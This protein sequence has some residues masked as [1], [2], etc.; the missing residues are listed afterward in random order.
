MK[1][2]SQLYKKYEDEIE[3][4]HN[5]V[6]EEAESRKIAEECLQILCQA[7]IALSMNNQVE[8]E[9]CITLA[10]SILAGAKKSKEYQK[11]YG[12]RIVL[13][14][15]LWLS[16]LL[17]LIPII[18]LRFKGEDVFVLAGVPI[19][20]YIWGGVG[21]ITS[22]LYSFITHSTQ[23]N[24]DT[25]LIHSYYLKPILGII[26]GPIVYFLFVCIVFAMGL[27]IDSKIPNFL[28]LLA[29]WIAGFSERFSLGMLDTVMD[30]L[31]NIHPRRRS[32][33]QKIEYIGIDREK[34]RKE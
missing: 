15:L 32:Q 5:L 21:G 1:G 27:D 33:I 6:I 9:Y 12:R 11:S 34:I 25:Q 29:C 10:K 2:N 8:A 22:A 24:L 14:E 13:Y 30:T 17:I 31:F 18:I 3:R 16:I 23:R 26:T 7:R 28:I 20:C 19:Q 4:L